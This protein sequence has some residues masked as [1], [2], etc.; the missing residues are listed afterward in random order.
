MKGGDDVGS[1]TYEWDKFPQVSVNVTPFHNA[2]CSQ[3]GHFEADILPKRY[4]YLILVWKTEEQERAIY[5]NHM[6]A[7]ETKA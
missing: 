2:S 4:N 7:Q 6:R 5:A 3:K 1:T